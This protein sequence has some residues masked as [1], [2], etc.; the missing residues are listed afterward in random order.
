MLITEPRMVSVFLTRA[1]TSLKH[2]PQSLFGLRSEIHTKPTYPSIIGVQII[3][4]LELGMSALD[5]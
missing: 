4:V 1:P 5:L 2:V 3:A